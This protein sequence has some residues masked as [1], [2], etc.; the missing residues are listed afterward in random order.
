MN[1]D[2]SV[3]EVD[4]GVWVAS[5]SCEWASEDWETE[6]DALLDGEDHRDEMGEGL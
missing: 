5:C 3:S 1:H 2:I 4:D 6:D